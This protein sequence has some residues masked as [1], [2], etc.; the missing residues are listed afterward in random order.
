M[1]K[2][3]LLMSVM[4]MACAVQAQT[5]TYTGTIK[6]L[7]M[8]VV[9]SGQVTFTLTP[10]VDST[11]HGIGRFTPTTTTCNINGNGTLSGYVNGVLN[12]PCVVASNTTLSPAGTS[13]QICI[14]PNF[15]TPGSCFY[16][17]ATTASKDISSV[18][19]TLT[20]GPLNYSGIPAPA[21]T[22]LGNWSSTTVYQLGQAVA[23]SD[24]VY[25]SLVNPNLNNSPSSSPS[26]WSV[27]QT[28]ASLT[29][30]PTVSQTVLQPASTSFSVNN[31]NGAL[32]AV[33][34]AGSDI[35]AKVNAAI[36]SF[37]STCGTVVIPAGVYS[38]STSILK[39]QCVLLK[40]QGGNT[41]STKLTFTGTT[42]GT[43][44]IVVA[45]IGAN[46][47]GTG[48]IEDLTIL[49]PSGFYGS[50]QP[51]GVYG[52][53]V[54]G[55]P[56]G[57][58]SS[59]SGFAENQ[60]FKNFREVGFGI[61][62]GFGNNAFW[63]SFYAP[64][65]QSNLVG[66]TESGSD[67]GEAISWYGGECTS[68]TNG[69]FVN[70]PYDNRIYDMGIDFNGT[71]TVPEITNSTIYLF[72]GHMEVGN[73]PLYSGSAL[74]AYGTNFF[75]DNTTPT[76]AWM[77]QATAAG[78]RISLTSCTFASNLPVTE[79]VDWTA[80]SGELTISHPNG[81]GNFEIAS[82]TQSGFVPFDGLTIDGSLNTGSGPY[83]STGYFGHPMQFGG[84]I[85]AQNS[86]GLP[87]LTLVDTTASAPTPT[88]KW[89][90]SGG[91]L[92]ILNDAGTV[93]FT[94]TDAGLL[95][96]G[97]GFST[98]NQAQVG[99]LTIGT[100]ATTL[101]NSSN[102]PTTTATAPGGTC[103]TPNGFVSVV[104]NG[105]TLHVATCP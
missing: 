90:I 68:N 86:A 1:K 8:N 75:E 80:A 33:L 39:P 101:F 5:T 48:G 19:P 70:A 74:V 58:M 57:V 6:D 85:S 63:D 26:D 37:G 9:T 94:L 43:A 10:A 96:A 12:G 42:S 28:P 87:S 15:S 54:G 100:G 84:P 27:V 11:I 40:G 97:G 62:I 82:L 52:L 81:N 98:T 35:G 17:H 77:F 16:D 105:V 66:V 102:I 99:G 95:T 41:L 30:S 78:S 2:F 103:T 13:Y 22:F 51:A 45:D 4:L 91:S 50:S 3:L 25:I 89:R 72:G 67:A 14:Q 31:L 46:S 7:S 61:G 79:L 59:S 65:I 64:I 69:C 55:D 60:V 93:I 56:A 36:A 34:F 92:Q 71:A 21:L 53:Y 20:T 73:G 47:N 18:A 44:A 104:V 24:T 76:L 49:S 83:S 38:Y 88:K 32:N 23:Y 29:T